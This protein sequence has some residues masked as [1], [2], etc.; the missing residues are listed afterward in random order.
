MVTAL[1]ENG[2]LAVAPSSRPINPVSSTS[3]NDIHNDEDKEEKTQELEEH[4][5]RLQDQIG[6]LSTLL[7]EAMEEK[8]AEMD[9]KFR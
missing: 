9:D 6:R 7:E 3:K 4:V 5:G 1:F 8:T 2:P